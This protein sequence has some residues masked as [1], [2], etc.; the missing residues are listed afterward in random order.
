MLPLKICHPGPGPW[1]P[2]RKY[3]PAEVSAIVINKSNSY[4]LHGRDIPANYEWKM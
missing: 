4:I 2:V 3:G 1:R